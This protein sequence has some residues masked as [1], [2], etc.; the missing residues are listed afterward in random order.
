MKKK[1]F[2]L[3]MTVLWS[4]VMVTALHSWAGIGVGVAMGAAFGLFGGDGG[5]DDSQQDTDEKQ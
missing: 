1:A 2:P 3:A 4:V 5:E